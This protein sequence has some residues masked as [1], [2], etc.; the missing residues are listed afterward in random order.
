MADV[1]N[2]VRGLVRGD[3]ASRFREGDY[4]YNI[5]VM[6]PEEKIVSRRDIENLTLNSTQGGYL[7]LRDVAQVTDAVGPVEIVR[8][9]QVKEVIVRGDAAGVSVGDALQ[10]RGRW[11]RWTSRSATSSPTAAR[12]R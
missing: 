6:V 12:P 5:R 4:Y 8:D 7:R 11:R 9:N 1:A 10:R 3:V 2:T